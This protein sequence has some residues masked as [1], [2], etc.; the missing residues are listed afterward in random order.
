MTRQKKTRWPLLS[1]HR[2][3]VGVLAIGLP[4]I[5]LTVQQVH[6]SRADTAEARD[7]RAANSE[8]KV[9]LAGMARRVQVVEVGY[10][11]AG[12]ETTYPGIV[13]AAETAEL[14]FRVGGPL[15]EVA[16]KPGDTVRRGDVLMRI[17]P[18]DFESAVRSAA[19]ALDSARAKLSAMKAGARREDVLALEA[20]MESAVARR[21]YLQAMYER[22][23]R[24]VAT[25]AVS[26]ATFD[27][28]ESELAAI[29]ADIE[30]LTQELEKAKSGARSEDVAAMEADI[31]GM[32]SRLESARDGLADATLRAP[33]D[34]MVA[35]RMVE[36]HEHL[37]AGT[38]V[39]VVHDIAQLKIDVALPDKELMHRPTN[40]P[41]RV[42][43]RFLAAPDR[44][45]DAALK[46]ISTESDPA[47]R[48]YLATFVMP[49]PPDL[50]ILPGMI[51]DVVL[52][53]QSQEN[54][55]GHVLRIPAA[56]LQSGQGGTWFVW[57][58]VNGAVH[59]KPVVVG[60]LSASDEYEV[61]KGIAPGDRVVAGGAAFLY[62]GAPV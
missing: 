37:S 1:K 58:V 61:V 20:R 28:S 8:M 16:V 18:R 59:Q 39:L 41:F 52:Q 56:A 21:K 10:A 49:S 60:N 13:R 40:A 15:V 51:S 19:A 3:L 23:E 2:W 34:G 4:A 38:T 43:V 17:D 35:R 42:A 22:N 14:A 9:P 26:R 25:N 50:N 44:A 62:Q 7:S 32:E 47:T 53:S 24:L 12:A 6:C 48:T 57:A 29:L 11:N 27:A 33:F 55:T 54:G 45:F 5:A 31:R 30:A 46:E 36:N